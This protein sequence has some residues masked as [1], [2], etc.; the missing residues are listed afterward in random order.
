MNI[1]KR[2]KSFGWLVI[3]YTMVPYSTG[4]ITYTYTTQSLTTGREITGSSVT[5]LFQIV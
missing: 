4:N 3:Q 5:G 2:R 1:K